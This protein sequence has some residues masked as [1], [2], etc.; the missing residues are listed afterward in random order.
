MVTP[1]SM[2]FLEHWQAARAFGFGDIRMLPARTV[3][4][5]CVLEN[6]S[7]MERSHDES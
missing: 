5:F 3:D 6:E 1:Q 4:A 2:E 7:A